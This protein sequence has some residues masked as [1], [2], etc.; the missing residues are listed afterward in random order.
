MDDK[1]Q[2]QLTQIR[3]QL[4]QLQAGSK[5]KL[6]MIVF[7]GELDKL[8]AAFNIA[9]GAVA[10][11]IEVVL[12]FTFWGTSAMRD[13]QKKVTGKNFFSRLF[14]W[15][16]PRGSDKLKLSKKNFAGLGSWMIRTLMKQKNIPSLAEM[17]DLSGKMGVK[18]YVCEM[19]MNLMGFHREEMIDYPGL[20]FC[21]VATYLAEARE[22][23]MQLFIA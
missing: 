16:L 13:P 21:G 6:S 8:I 17:I 10:S 15:M 5:N 11:G 12:F 9:T 1:I 20:K 19:S 2:D 18:I 3:E 23:K 22:S 7:S 14:G 4:S